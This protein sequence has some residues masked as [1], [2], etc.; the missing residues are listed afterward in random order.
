MSESIERKAENYLAQGRVSVVEVSADRGEFQVAGSAAMPYTVLF[1]GEW[2]CSCEARIPRCAHVVACQKI[3]HFDP[4]RKIMFN[5]GE[6]SDI[7]AILAD[8]F[9][10]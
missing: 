4:A 8:A 3:T 10:R 1:E 9:G 2:M 7:D 6:E 5:S